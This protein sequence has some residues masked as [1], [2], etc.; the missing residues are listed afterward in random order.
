M[1]NIN[2]NG[3]DLKVGEADAQLEGWTL[4]LVTG[5]TGSAR[6]RGKNRQVR[7]VTHNSL[8]GEEK[9]ALAIAISSGML[10]DNF[11]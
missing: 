4:V 8:S 9:R 11:L 7:E 6:V 3:V 5:R 10:D 1:V 2:I